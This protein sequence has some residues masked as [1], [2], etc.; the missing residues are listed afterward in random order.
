M[1]TVAS[2]LC[3]LCID[4]ALMASPARGQALVR[5]LAEGAKIEVRSP[6]FD[7]GDPIPKKYTCDGEGVRPPLAWGEVPVGTRS[8]AVF[9][10]D[11]GYL[12]TMWTLWSAYNLPPDLRQLP[13]GA[14]LPAGAQEG[15]GDWGKV[16]YD[17][18]CPKAG[19]RTY[20]VTVYALNAPVDEK[21]GQAPLPDDLK[22][23]MDL[24]VLGS[25][26]LRFTYERAAATP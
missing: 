15:Q 12:K 5:G 7:D 14:P 18:P 24:K 10:E 16:G 4:L 20:V 8:L 6:A 3:L 17:P 11:G 21:V 2:L 22:N 13:E 23:A 9:I 25:G 26:H 19:K 1:R